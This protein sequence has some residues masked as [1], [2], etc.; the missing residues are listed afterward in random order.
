MSSGKLTLQSSDGA[1]ITV[2]KE[3][4]ERSLLIKNMVGDLGEEATSAPIPIPNVSQI[5]LSA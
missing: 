2:D 1:D 3:V 4:A 5:C